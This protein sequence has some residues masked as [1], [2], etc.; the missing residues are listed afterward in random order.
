MRSLSTTALLLTLGY[1]V[2][3]CL[4]PLLLTEYGY[5][6]GLP[7]WFWFSCILAPLMLI[8]FLVRTLGKT[9]D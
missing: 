6:Y 5:W 2:L 4:G 1:F 8:I 7:I 9:N 3:W